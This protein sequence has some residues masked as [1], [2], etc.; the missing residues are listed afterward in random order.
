[1]DTVLMVL[2]SLTSLGFDLRTSL[3]KTWMG[4]AAWQYLVAFL[5]VLTSLLARR[6]AT[7][8]LQRL[9]LPSLE[10]FG[11][12]IASRL[13]GALIQ[14]LTALIGLIGVFLAVN[15]LLIP[16]RPEPTLIT[17]TFVRQ[18]FEVAIA[19]IVI[20]ALMRIVDELGLH[21]KEQAQKQDL[22]IEAPVIPLLQKS[23]K[24]FV[25]I[26]GGILVIQE[27]GYPIASLLGGLGIGGLAVALAAQDTIANVF[28]SVIVFTD[29]PFKV[30]DW[31]KIGDVEGFV[32][33]IGFR[34]TRIRTW[35][36]SLV[37]VP[38]KVIANSQ[39]E[40]WSAMPIRRIT[41]TL[42]IAYG[43]RPDQI[44]ALVEGIREIL[45]NHPG[46]DQG[47]HL[48]NFT[49]FSPEGLGIYVYYFTR[50]TVWKEHMQVRQ[51]IN[52]AIMRLVDSLGLTLGVPERRVHVEPSFDDAGTIDAHEALPRSRSRGPER[53]TLATDPEQ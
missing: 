41:F 39:I 40:N 18:V 48:V 50:S 20:W 38:N 49:E 15:V 52:L 22:P 8:L 21:F 14:P 51:E 36:K 53:P 23:L 6:M 37:T 16:T 47:F 45:V 43:A 25:A 44:E 1:M 26:V 12:R 29:K 4:I 42:R 34:S 5:L 33:N 7:K 9:I 30:G 27:L 24:F 31:I 28:G 2:D 11:R 17:P 32:E 19:V 46:V 13:V 3:S 10:R 35:P